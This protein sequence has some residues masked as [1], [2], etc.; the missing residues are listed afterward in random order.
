MLRPRARLWAAPV[1][2]L[3]IAL[4]LG[5]DRAAEQELSS[6]RRQAESMRQKN[7]SLQ[8][9]LNEAGSTLEQ[10]RTEKAELKEEV[11]ELQSRTGEVDSL[12]E[13]VREA[14]EK[15]AALSKQLEELKAEREPAGDGPDVAA[16]RSRLTALGEELFEKSRYRSAR[17]AL[18]SARELGAAA[19][20]TA[21]RIA[22]SSAA[23]EDRP[24][25]RKWYET[26]L[27]A[28]D[29]QAQPDRALRL[30]C[31]NNYA[32][33]LLKSGEPEQAVEF[34]RRA[35]DLDAS[36]APAHFNLGLAYKGR[37]DSPQRAIEAF[38]NHV[39]H[40]GVRTESARKLIEDLLPEETSDEEPAD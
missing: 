40:G 11:D 33:L 16:A 20:E 25:A 18:L 30:K 2:L 4:S 29:E 9:E 35:L 37:G 34:C 39:A 1:L 21:Y 17:S 23:L 3:G 10:L 38:R 15:A 27:N 19:P 31:L 22:Y 24:A 28:I 14:D 8:A 32:A 26:A 36:Y 6:L 12:R 7:E 5:C 13:R